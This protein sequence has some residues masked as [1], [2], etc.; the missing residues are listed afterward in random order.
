MVQALAARYGFDPARTPWD[1]MTPASQHAFLFGDPEPL[2]V[3]YTGRSGRTHTAR[4]VFRGFYGW[5]G[6]WDLG[7]TYTAFEPCPACGGRRLRPEYL[8]VTLGG[9]EARPERGALARLAEVLDGVAGWLP[10]GHRPR[11]TWPP[12]AAGCTFSR[13]WGSATCT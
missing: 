2:E 8:A 7:G 12:P 4:H 6:E 11:P 3:R 1:E 5:V 9:Q 13:R 10:E